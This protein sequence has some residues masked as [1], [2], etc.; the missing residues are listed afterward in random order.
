[1]KSHMDV[2]DTLNV[3]IDKKLNGL[4]KQIDSSILTI[5]ENPDDENKSQKLGV[6]KDVI[7]A[8]IG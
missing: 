4:T 3:D 1:M 2:P 5:K 8:I 7:T 6:W